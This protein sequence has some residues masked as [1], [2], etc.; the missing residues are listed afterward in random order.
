VGEKELESEG[1]DYRNGKRF[2][3]LTGR[4]QPFRAVDS[5]QLR[6]QDYMFAFSN[7]NNS[8]GGKNANNGDH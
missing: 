7:I 4:G 1:K 2:Q 6:I 5:N 3:V 8:I